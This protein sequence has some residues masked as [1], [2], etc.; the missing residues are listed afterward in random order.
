MA[1]PFH[2]NRGRFKKKMS[3]G[4][5]NLKLTGPTKRVAL[6]VGGLEGFTPLPQNFENFG[7]KC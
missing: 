5:Y 4:Q 6:L 3:T 2:L 7:A 1:L